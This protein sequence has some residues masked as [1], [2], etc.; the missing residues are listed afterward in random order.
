MVR[1]VHPADR[2]HRRPPRSHSRSRT[3]HPLPKH[4]PFFSGST[5]T[6]PILDPSSNVWRPTV[7]PRSC[8]LSSDASYTADSSQQEQSWTMDESLNKISHHQPLSPPASMMEKREAEKSP[9]AS[10]KSFHSAEEAASTSEGAEAE[11]AVIGPQGIS[12][13]ATVHPSPQ[14]VPGARAS[15]STP[16]LRRVST[17]LT[18]HK[19]ES[20]QDLGGD[21]LI[22]QKWAIVP[23]GG[24]ILPMRRLYESGLYKKC[25]ERVLYFSNPG[26]ECVI[27]SESLTEMVDRHYK[28]CEKRGCES[29]EFS[30]VW[31]CTRD[32][33][34]EAIVCL[35][36]A[37][38]YANHELARF[39]PPACPEC[40]CLWPINLLRTQAEEYKPSQPHPIIPPPLDHLIGDQSIAEALQSGMDRFRQ[41]WVRNFKRSLDEIKRDEYLWFLKM[42]YFEGGFEFD[43]S[44]ELQAVLVAVWE[45]SH[46][47]Q[48][49]ELGP[50]QRRSMGAF[51]AELMPLPRPMPTHAHALA[52]AQTVQTRDTRSEWPTPQGPSSGSQGRLSELPRLIQPDH[53][54]RRQRMP[55]RGSSASLSDLRPTQEGQRFSTRVPAGYRMNRNSSSGS[56]GEPTPALTRF[57]DTL[58]HTADRLLEEGDFTPEDRV[59]RHLRRISSYVDTARVQGPAQDTTRRQGEQELDK[60]KTK[61]KRLLKKIASLPLMLF[62]KPPPE[63]AGSTGLV[64]RTD[65]RGRAT[66]PPLISISEVNSPPR[67]G[68]EPALATSRSSPRI[69]SSA[70]K[71]ASSSTVNGRPS[72][73]RSQTISPLMP[74][75][76]AP[77]APYVESFE[78]SSHTRSVSAGHHRTAIYASEAPLTGQ[79]PSTSTERFINEHLLSESDFGSV[80][81]AGGESGAVGGS[82]LGSVRSAVTSENGST[83]TSTFH[84]AS[85]SSQITLDRPP[86]AAVSAFP[87]NTAT[88]GHAGDDALVTTA[89][90][91]QNLS[92]RP[93][94]NLR[95]SVSAGS[96]PTMDTTGIGATSSEDSVATPTSI[97]VISLNT[98]TGGAMAKSHSSESI[99][100]A[101]PYH[102]DFHPELSFQL[103]SLRSRRNLSFNVSVNNERSADGLNK[104]NIAIVE[105]PGDVLSGIDHY[106]CPPDETAKM[107]VKER[108]SGYWSGL[109]KMKN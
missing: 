79:T 43:P 63:P 21:R 29:H 57:L 66:G 42:A 4:D 82:T 85:S 56:V 39:R 2:S 30:C 74:T 28:E 109:F 68:G 104:T 34:C 99:S 100:L 50:A 103:H 89:S 15:P 65:R 60:P 70:D 84:T 76:A 49:K 37:V 54:S 88:T 18:P 14:H 44:E 5:G 51:P 32:N 107:A 77:H 75:P 1:E 27:C 26:N 31:A 46:P 72:H 106:S 53:S 24:I 22:C 105:I 13:N 9:A 12:P 80:K 90:A 87:S 97:S 38:D 35:D 64:H 59:H 10:N 61:K 93:P 108:K 8:S 33:Q 92:V 16:K 102:Q 45:A 95:H 71:R 62:R 98:L 86:S 94:P 36:C 20:K 19:M 40:D 83:G 48:A 17:K 101:T 52:L 11:S 96:M 25:G 67:T 6:P 3:R 55:L 47:L 78:R 73:T 91:S 7:S 41:L 58:G 69:V 81:L 23:N